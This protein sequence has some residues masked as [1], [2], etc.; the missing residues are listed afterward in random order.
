MC[1][2]AVLLENE[3][4]ERSLIRGKRVRPDWWSMSGGVV[5]AMPQRDET[6]EEIK[7][8]VEKV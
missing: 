5:M 7:R 1:N 4:A 3:N 2:V 6:I 8:L